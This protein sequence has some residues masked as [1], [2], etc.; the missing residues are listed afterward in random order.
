MIRG[1]YE[2]EA[3]SLEELLATL[4]GIARTVQDELHIEIKRVVINGVAY[5][6]TGTAFK[7]EP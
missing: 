1:R 6:W 4:T 7:R 5:S 2:V 3:S